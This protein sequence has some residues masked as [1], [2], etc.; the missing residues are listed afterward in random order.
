MVDR[1]LSRPDAIGLK[2][3][4]TCP[5]NTTADILRNHRRG[6]AGQH[7]VAIAQDIQH[8]TP[9]EASHTSSTRG[10]ATYFR[11]R[12]RRQI[13]SE[14]GED[15]SPTKIKQTHKTGPIKIPGTSRPACHGPPLRRNVSPPRSAPVSAARRGGGVRARP[16]YVQLGRGRGR[17]GGAVRCVA[18]GIRDV[19]E[20]AVS[21][22]RARWTGGRPEGLVFARRR[23]VR[24]TA[25]CAYIIMSLRNERA[26]DSA[27]DSALRRSCAIFVGAAKRRGHGL[28]CLTD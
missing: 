2:T 12:V 22:G 9:T 24:Q 15:N 20:R 21:N 3:K 27:L 16:G 4:P 11:L 8:A 7:V 28:T 14:P 13:N 18:A 26:L 25:P 23:A 5:I 10:D 19:T 6:L 17:G 1:Y